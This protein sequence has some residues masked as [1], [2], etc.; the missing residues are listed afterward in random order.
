[1]DLSVK[2]GK[3]ILKNPVLV[4]SGTFGYGKEYKDLIGINKLGAFV[5]KTITLKPREGNLPPRIVETPSGILNSIGLEN[6]G[7]EVFIKEKLPFLKTL[8]TAFVVSIAGYTKEEFSKLAKQ[9][10]DEGVK[11]FELNI[12]CPNIEYRKGKLNF[13]QDAKST[14]AVVKEVKKSTKLTVITK[15][16]PNVTDISEIAKSAEEAGSDAM[17]L[18]NTILGMAVDIDT[19]KPLL[20][21]ITGGLSGPAVKPVAL[22]VV[23]EVYNSVKIPIIGMGGIMD[24]NDAI[25]FIISGAS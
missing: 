6:C 19:K 18:I 21:N 4:A 10:E 5:T 25:E 3:L 24:A 8:K 22:R 13:S 1:M 2:I 17:S 14:Y 12:S 7:L 15:L 11:A 23:W 20:G 16:S 9:L